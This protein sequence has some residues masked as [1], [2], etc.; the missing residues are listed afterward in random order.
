VSDIV[1]AIDAERVHPQYQLA[2]FERPVQQQGV[3]GEESG[4][5]D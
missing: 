1:A 5:V 3:S 2:L 4:D